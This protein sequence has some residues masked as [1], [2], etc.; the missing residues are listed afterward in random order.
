MGGCNCILNHPQT[1]EER[2]ALLIDLWEHIRN[3][4]QTG[5]S[6][7]FVRL[8]TVCGEGLG[9]QFPVEPHEHEV[10]DG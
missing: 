8:F 10:T 2:K 1:K 7:S 4:D 3:N 5:A 6:V 9:L